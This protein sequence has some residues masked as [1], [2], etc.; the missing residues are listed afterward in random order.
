M[1]TSQTSG[2]FTGTKTS[3]RGSNQ[4]GMRNYNERLMLEKIREHGQLSKADLAKITGL[5][6]QTSTIIANRLIEDGLLCKQNSVKGKVGQ[7][8]TPISLDANGAYSFGIKV[9]RRSVEIFLV[10]FCYR[11]V[12]QKSLRYK[13]A[14]P[15]PIFEWLCKNI[16]EII[17]RLGEEKSARILGIGLAQPFELENWPELIGAPAGTMDSWKDFDLRN[18]IFLATQLPTYLLNDASAACLAELS[19]QLEGTSAS[20]LYVYLGTFIG[21]GIVFE[22]KLFEGSTG[23]AGALAS[24]PLNL[25]GSPQGQSGQLLEKASFNSLELWAAQHGVGSDILSETSPTVEVEKQVTQ[26]ISEAANGIAMAIIAGQ[27]ILD[28]NYV[29]L[30]SSLPRHLKERVASSTEATLAQY[31]QRGISRPVLTLGTLGNNARALGAALLP[32]RTNFSADEAA[33]AIS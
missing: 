25:F 4:R 17:A 32:F 18:E 8:R 22:G 30:D 28:M 15:Q 19:L 5:S 11:I 27:A 9:G 24:L 26:W 21:G 31:D 16:S 33:F 13:F 12:E 29:V 2:S 14:E 3:R 6:P 20:F 10:D 23:N 7:P 1:K